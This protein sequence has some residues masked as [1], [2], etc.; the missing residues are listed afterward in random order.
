MKRPLPE[1]K[2]P[3]NLIEMVDA[4]EGGIWEDTE[5]LAPLTLT[6]M[7]DTIYCG[8]EIPLAWQIEFCPEDEEFEEANERLQAAGLEPNGYGWATLV[9]GIAQK[10]HS[11]I[12]SELQFGDTETSAFVVWVEREQACRTATEILWNVIFAG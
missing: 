3:S 8:R 11:D 5:S 7:K 4:D 6:V 1:W 9:N 10:Y 2:M 12:A